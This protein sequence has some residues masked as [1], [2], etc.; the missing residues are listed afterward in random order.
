[1]H[2]YAQ[3]LDLNSSIYRPG[4]AYLM[5]MRRREASHVQ[6]VAFLLLPRLATHFLLPPT[7]L[8]LQLALSTTSA[9]S[10]PTIISTTITPA[11][12]IISRIIG[13]FRLRRGGGG[14]LA[15]EKCKLVNQ[16]SIG[17]CSTL[18]AFIEDNLD[19]SGSE[20]LLIPQFH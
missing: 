19:T 14:G 4:S 13:V 9:T 10:L 16:A 1:M 20:E 17:A 5:M 11:I 2:I 6:R 15:L 3:H 7:L 12:A 8:F 18:T